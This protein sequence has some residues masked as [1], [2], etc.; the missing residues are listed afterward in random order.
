[1]TNTARKAKSKSTVYL[2]NKIKYSF[3]G[4]KYSN[5]QAHPLDTL[6]VMSHWILIFMKWE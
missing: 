4:F 6:N 2:C 1:M 5:L 3:G